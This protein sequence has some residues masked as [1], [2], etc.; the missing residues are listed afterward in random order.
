[1]LSLNMVQWRHLGCQKFL[2]P[3]NKRH[4]RAKKLDLSSFKSYCTKKKEKKKGLKE[5]ASECAPKEKKRM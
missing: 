3:Q 4:L 2:S 1:M 5:T